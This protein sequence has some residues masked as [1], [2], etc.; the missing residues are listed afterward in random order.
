MFSGGGQKN[1][2]ST[3]ENKL[4]E[5]YGIVKYPT[6][7]LIDPNGNIVEKDVSVYNLEYILTKYNL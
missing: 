4:T 3:D 6:G 5:I 2:L 7:I 1:I